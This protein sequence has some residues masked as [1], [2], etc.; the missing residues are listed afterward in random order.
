MQPAAL[1]SPAAVETRSRSRE[2]ARAKQSTAIRPPQ[3]KHTQPAQPPKRAASRRPQ[4]AR[5]LL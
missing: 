5:L 3:R 1:C 2:T 4:R